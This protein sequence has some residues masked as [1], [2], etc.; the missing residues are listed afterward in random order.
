MS[1]DRRVLNT[2]I[3]RTCGGKGE[4]EATAKSFE[5][6]VWVRIKPLRRTGICFIQQSL[7]RARKSL[8]G[9]VTWRKQACQSTQELEEEP[10]LGVFGGVSC[11]RFL[12]PNSS[13]NN[14]L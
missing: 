8:I 12:M 1:K 14:S 6:L 2:D 4:V 11:K 7:R 5:G 10:G 3:K 9:A 13:I